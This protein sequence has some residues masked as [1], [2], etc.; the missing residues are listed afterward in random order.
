MFTVDHVIGDVVLRE[1]AVYR[2]EILPHLL[3]RQKE[4]IIRHPRPTQVPIGPANGDGVAHPARDTQA[5]DAASALPPGVCGKHCDS[6]RPH[7]RQCG[8]PSTSGTH[9]AFTA[10][11][12]EG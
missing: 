2:A 3:V 8:S 10:K 4:P 11:H 1:P 6:T 12:A 5:A 9:R 7:V